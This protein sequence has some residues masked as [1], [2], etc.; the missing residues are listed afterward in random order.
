MDL[1]PLAPKP[2]QTTAN[3]FEVIGSDVVDRRIIVRLLQ[4]VETSLQ[5]SYEAFPQ[6]VHRADQLIRHRLIQTNYYQLLDLMDARFD[7]L[8]RNRLSIRCYN[9]VWSGK[10]IVCPVNMW[11]VRNAD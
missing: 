2:S 9:D 5:C 11:C 3:L 4:T 7:V 8:R 1:R 10:K 6:I